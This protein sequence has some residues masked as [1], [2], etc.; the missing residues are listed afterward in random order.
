VDKATSSAADAKA[1]LAG[2]AAAGQDSKVVEF[3]VS[4][5]LEKVAGI[6]TVS[7]KVT[8]VS[9]SHAAINKIMSVGVVEKYVAMALSSRVSQMVTE[10]Q[11]STF[12]LDKA[13]AKGGELVTTGLAKGREL[14]SVGVARGEEI[15]ENLKQKSQA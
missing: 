1:N 6:E 2:A 4:T 11:N 8:A 7:A 9:S 15:V 3:D 10:W 14:A 13:R 12:T 5:D